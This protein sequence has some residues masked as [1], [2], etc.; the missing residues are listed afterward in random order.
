MFPARFFRLVKKKPILAL[1]DRAWAIIDS[2]CI[3]TGSH[4]ES[5]RFIWSGALYWLHLV[6]PVP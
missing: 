1:M 3:T 6:E 4:G 5:N 2:L